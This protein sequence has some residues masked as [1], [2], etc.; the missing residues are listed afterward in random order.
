MSVP[1]FLGVRVKPNVACC[2]GFNSSFGI[3]RKEIGGG[4]LESV[5]A[6]LYGLDDFED[7]VNVI[8]D[9]SFLKALD[10]DLEVICTLNFV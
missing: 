4:C 3:I 9:K 5:I 7:T 10:H 2:D 6:R 8:F 1:L